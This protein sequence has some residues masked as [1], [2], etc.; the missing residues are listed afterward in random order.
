MADSHLS[1]LTST[2]CEIVAASCLWALLRSTDSTQLHRGNPHVAEGTAPRDRI[3]WAGTGIAC[4][5][6]EQ[7]SV[8][9]FEQTGTGSF[10]VLADMVNFEVGFHRC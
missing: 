8:P 10:A 2:S 1:D 6:P 9:D 3:D 5:P 4:S 7:E